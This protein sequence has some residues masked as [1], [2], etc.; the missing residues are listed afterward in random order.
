MN[1]NFKA[2][3]RKQQLSKLYSLYDGYSALLKNAQQQKDFIIAHAGSLTPD[4]YQMLLKNAEGDIA[5]ARA[6]IGSMIPA[7][8]VQ[9][10]AKPAQ[11][12]PV[13]SCTQ[14]NGLQI[15]PEQV[16][17]TQQDSQAQNAPEM[18][19]EEQTAQSSTLL[20][21]DSASVGWVIAGIAG[22]I[23][24]SI[25]VPRFIEWINK[26]PHRNIAHV[27]DFLNEFKNA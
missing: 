13:R 20:E 23:G 10:E 19:S 11:V 22:I 16:A 1:Q 17:C 12:T 27:R 8:P 3:S 7:T 6:K 9:L 4:K 14:S 2:M 15:L 25:G 5:F 24:L 21:T 26:D 18:V